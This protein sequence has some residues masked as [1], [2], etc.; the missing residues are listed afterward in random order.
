MTAPDAPVTSAVLFWSVVIVLSLASQLTD[1]DDATT[2]LHVL[3]PRLR[4]GE[5]T[6]DVDVEHTIHLLQRRLL[7]RFRSCRAG[8]VH[9]HI[10][11]AEGRDA[12]STAPWTASTFAASAW[13]AMAFPPPSSIALTTAEL[14]LRPLHT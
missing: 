5:Y 4:G 13:I 14:R 7:E 12:F 1:H 10:K 2:I 6:A 11:P 3:Q 9:E 8:I